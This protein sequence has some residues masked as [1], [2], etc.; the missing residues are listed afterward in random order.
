MIKTEIIVKGVTK[1]N[2]CQITNIEGGFG[3]E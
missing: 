1:I 3:G 2:G